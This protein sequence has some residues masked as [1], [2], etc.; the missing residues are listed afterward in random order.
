MVEKKLVIAFSP[1]QV[2]VPITFRLAKDYDLDVNILRAEVNERGGKLILSLKGAGEVIDKAIVFLEDSKVQVGE[3]ARFVIRDAEL[4]TDCSM[5]VSI[6]PVRAYRLDQDD[7]KVVFDQERCIACAL[8]VDACPAQ[9]LRCGD[10]TT[11]M[12]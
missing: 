6:C 5:C 8:C 2:N 12:V 4:C 9:A 11:Q 1:E 7:W 10:N 3:V